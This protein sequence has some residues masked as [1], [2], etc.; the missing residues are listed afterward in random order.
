MTK[1]DPV[2][3][4]RGAVGL[5]GTIVDFLH[6]PLAN[7]QFDL[8]LKIETKHGMFYEYPHNLNRSS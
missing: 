5:T 4:V 6:V 2:I 8:L 1:G 7:S 3:W